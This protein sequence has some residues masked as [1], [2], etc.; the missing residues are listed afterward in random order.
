PGGSIT[1]VGDRGNADF[2]FEVEG[3]KGTASVASRSRLFE[4]RWDFTQLE[5]TFADNERIDLSR[6][7][8]GADDGTP[9]FDPMAEMPEVQMP[10]LPRNIEFDLPPEAMQ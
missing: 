3:P 8:A 1:V 2:H 7:M 5:I 10:D 9:K 6:R 4:D